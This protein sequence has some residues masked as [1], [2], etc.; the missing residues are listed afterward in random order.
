MLLRLFS[1]PWFFK[2]PGIRHVRLKSNNFTSLS[3]NSGTSP[4]VRDSPH[5]YTSDL[6]DQLAGGFE[7]NPKPLNP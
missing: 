4:E 1:G 2:A 7:V 5:P 3:K 6:N